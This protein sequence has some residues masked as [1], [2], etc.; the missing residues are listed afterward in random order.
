MYFVFMVLWRYASRVPE[1]V[2][3]KKFIFYGLIFGALL[4]I[5][6]EILQKYLDIGRSFDIFDI[7]ANISGLIFVFLINKN[8][9]DEF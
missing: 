4:G 5:I 3:K 9:K 8:F 1:I 7:L 2:N 6:L